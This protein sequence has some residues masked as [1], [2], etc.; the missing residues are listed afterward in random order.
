LLRELLDDLHRDVRI[1]EACALGRLGRSEVRALLVGY[2]REEPTA[3]LIDAIAPIADEE[4]AVLLGRVARSTP[5][6]F[7]PLCVSVM[8]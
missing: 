8:G 5:H 1:A 7:E 4:C 2:L 3:E 6:L